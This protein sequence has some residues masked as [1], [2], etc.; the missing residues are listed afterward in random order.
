MV[1]SKHIKNEYMSKGF[2]VLKKFLDTQEISELDKKI[3]TFIEK[4]ANNLKG[5][6]INFTLKDKKIN[7]MHDIDKFEESFKEI[8]HQTKFL[9]LAENLLDSKAEFRKCEVFA[10]PANSGLASPMH[11]DN[12]LWAVKNNNGLTFWIALDFCNK[13]NGGLTYLEGSHKMGLIEHEPSFAP[14]TS[15]KIAEKF[16]LENKDKFKSITPELEPGDMLVHHCL[17]AHGSSENKSEKSRRGFTI[18]YKDFNSPYDEE[19]LDHY[20]KSLREQLVS[21]NQI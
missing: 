6:D 5:K 15:Q 2:V 20:N 17:V 13:K 9:E 7:T 4:K 21:R 16:F 10:K 19:L 14:G 8:A 18:Q 3:K 11:Q 12:Y 1:V